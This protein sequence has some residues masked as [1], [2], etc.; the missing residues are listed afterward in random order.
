MS[1]FTKIF[2]I[3][4]IL[5]IGTF[6][7]Q[8]FSVPSQERLSPTQLPIGDTS[9]P[10]SAAGVVPTTVGVSPADTRPF[11]T[12][13]PEPPDAHF[14]A[15]LGS[16]YDDVYAIFPCTLDD[17]QVNVVMFTART[18]PTPSGPTYDAAEAA[19]VSWE[20]YLL[21]D[22]GHMIYPD[23]S[24][25]VSPGLLSFAQVGNTSFKKA[26]ATFVSSQADI[27][28][29]WRLNYVFYASSPE[30]LAAAMDLVYEAH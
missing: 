10:R 9:L 12:L 7:V 23:R 18:A 19:V 1:T 3:L 21:S 8:L 6:A 27:Y 16:V 30:C 14:S 29:G 13:L 4:F 25:P 2:L 11:T 26:R 28:T 20:P 15:M 17:E 24:V 22:I 5:V